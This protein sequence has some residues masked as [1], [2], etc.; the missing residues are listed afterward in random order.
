MS[1]PHRTMAK[2]IKKRKGPV[3]GESSEP[4]KSSR[5]GKSTEVEV[6]NYDPSLDEDTD[7]ESPETANLSRFVLLRLVSAAECP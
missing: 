3:S 4:P 2:D 7:K 1:S 6:D 5:S